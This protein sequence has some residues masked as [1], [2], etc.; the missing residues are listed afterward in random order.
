MQINFQILHKNGWQSWIFEE[1]VYF[2]FGSVTLHCNPVE[3]TWKLEGLDETFTLWADL[4]R[5]YKALT[6]KEFVPGHA[7]PES[8]AYLK[9]A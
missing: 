6:G 7:I 1:K 4:L 3:R 2:T 5:Y 8:Q 9:R